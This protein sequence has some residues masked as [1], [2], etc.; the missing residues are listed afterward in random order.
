MNGFT[1]WTTSLRTSFATYAAGDHAGAIAAS[2]GPNRTLRKSYEAA[3]AHAVTV[4]HHAQGSAAESVEQNAHR[5][6]VIVL[7]CAGVA[8]ALGSVIAVWLVRRV[9]GPL[10]RLIVLMQPGTAVRAA[11]D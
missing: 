8:I 10:H 2:L 3:L 9:A 4:A 7:I 11:G 5:S 6:V 1:I